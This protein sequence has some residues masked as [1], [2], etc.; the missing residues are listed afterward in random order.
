MA[1]IKNALT[2]YYVGEWKDKETEAEMRLAHLI[3]TVTDDSNE[4]IEEEGFYDGDGTAEQDITSVQKGYTFEGYMDH[5][6]EAMAFIASKEFETGE[7]RKIAFTQIRTDGTKLHGKATVSEIKVTGG[8]ATD[9]P[10]F[11]CKITW[12]HKPFELAGVS[13]P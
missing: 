2:E 13:L 9:Y 7:G 11:S 10:V 6:D 3:T 4:E 12:D 5:E 8:E 1:R